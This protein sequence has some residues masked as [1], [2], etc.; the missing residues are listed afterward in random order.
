[1][2][3]LTKHSTIPYNLYVYDNLTHYKIQEHFLYWSILYEKGLISQVTFNTEDSTFNAFSKAV[4]SNQFGFSHTID[5][6]RDKY[7][8]LL[9]LD[10][11]IIV[12]PGFDIILNDAWEEIKN[13]SIKDKVKIV[14]QSPGGIMDRKILKFQIAKHDAVIGKYSGS[15]FW[16]VKPNFFEDVGFLKIS[17]LIGL[18]KKHDQEYWRLLEKFGC[19]YVVGLNAKLALHCGGIAGSI[20]NSL[21]NI[22]DK[23]VALE[24]IK[25]ELADEEID[26]LTFDQFYSKIC[27]REELYKW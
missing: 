9:F 22:K 3:A 26:K 16:C 18:N 21:T 25:F 27:D 2:T 24:K 11:D 20:C 23:E 7:N 15:G 12:H 5:P 10:N 13:S 1:V 6:N 4:A 14:T 19:E 17:R 8:F